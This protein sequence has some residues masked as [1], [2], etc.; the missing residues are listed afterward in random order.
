MTIFRPSLLVLLTLPLSLVG[1]ATICDH[2]N[3]PYNFSYTD[4]RST[5]KIE[6]YEVNPLKIVSGILSAK[7][8]T[9]NLIVT[10]A[11]TNKEL[12]EQYSAPKINRF[13]TNDSTLGCAK[14]IFWKSMP[15]LTRKTKTGKSEWRD[16][17]QKSHTILIS[18]FDK[19]Y[20][21]LIN[22]D[23]AE[24]DLSSYILN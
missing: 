13:R 1:C 22:W 17:V 3:A 16:V 18:G 11:V 14:T 19:D 23:D 4:N 2:L 6:L 24:Y 8:N 7:L 5:E 20:E 15:D 12:Y 9:S 21:Y 10:V